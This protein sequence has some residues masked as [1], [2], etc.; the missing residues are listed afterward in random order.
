MSLLNRSLFSVEKTLMYLSVEIVSPALCEFV[1]FNFFFKLKKTV[2][3]KAEMASTANISSKRRQSPVLLGGRR[4]GVTSI[5]V[6]TCNTY[7]E[8]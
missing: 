7:S 5:F 6:L 4:D 3:K 1:Q 2:F 8:W